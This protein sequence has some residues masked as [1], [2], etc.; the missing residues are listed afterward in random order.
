MLGQI[1]AV[2]GMNLRAWRQRFVTS[3]VSVIGIA[4]VVVILTA[5]LSIGEGFRRTLDLAGSDR[6]VIVLRGGSSAELTSTLSPE[7]VQIIAAAPGVMQSESGP[8]ASAELYTAVDLAKRSTGT[9]ANAPLRGIGPAGVMTHEHFKLLAGR[10]FVSGRN[11]VIVG[12]A[13]TRALQG[14]DPGAQLRWGNNTWQVVGV[15][16]DNGSVSESEIWTDARS[17][18]SAYALGGSFQSLRVLLTSPKALASF[19]SYISSDPRLNVTV[20]TERQFYAEQSSVLTAVVRGTGTVLALLMGIGAVFGALNTMYTA[21]ASRSAEIATLRAL[22]FGS[23]PILIS[24]LVEALLLALIGGVVGAGLA[25]VGF[26]GLQT[27]TLNF[28]SFS[29]VS[30]AFSVTPALMLTA[31]S[32]ALLL[33]LLGGLLPAL[34]ATRQS[35]VAGLRAT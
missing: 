26:D 10:M 29:L 31:V 25:Y 34:H 21:V 23:L 35:I 6:V 9:S 27:S 1:L 8:V 13:A 30:F 14:L 28:A 22:G 2:T 33:G 18:Q 20:M 17:L 3:L 5:V 11:E 16:S 24:V 4:G 19:K 12:Q 15:F 32:Y 7:Q